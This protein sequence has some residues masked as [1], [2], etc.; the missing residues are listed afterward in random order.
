MGWL[1]VYATL[2]FG[3]AALVALLAD[4]RDRSLPWL[5]ALLWPLLWLYLVMEACDLFRRCRIES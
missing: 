4:E 3:T 2:G 5:A 1:G